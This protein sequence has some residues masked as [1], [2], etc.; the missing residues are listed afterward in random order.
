MFQ[1]HFARERSQAIRPFFGAVL[2][3]LQIKLEVGSMRRRQSPAQRILK[4][5]IPQP[6][7]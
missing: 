5:L 2:I 1:H 4:Q 6:A 7:F 3:L